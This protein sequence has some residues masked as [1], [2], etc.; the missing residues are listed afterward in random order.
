LTFHPETFPEK[1]IIMKTVHIAAASALLAVG[2]AAIAAPDAGAN[3]DRPVE[4]HEGSVAYV[5][6]GIGKSDQM[7]M[8]RLGAA[9]PLHIVLSARKDDEFIA[10]V[11]VDIRDPKGR[12]VFHIDKAD[13]LLDVKLPEG[14]YIVNARFEG[15]GE[16]QDVL[17]AGKGS[18]TLYFHWKGRDGA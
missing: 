12:T 9:Y 16:S 18:Q 2:A 15:V 3:A 6:G 8:R 13:P 7:T 10:D 17:L 4:R 1:E 5:T 11:P 14:K